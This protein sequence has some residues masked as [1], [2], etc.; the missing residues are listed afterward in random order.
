M[1]KTVLITGSS[2]GIGKA[3]VEYF[4]REGWNVAATMRKP[5][6]TLFSDFENVSVYELDVTKPDTIKK[7]FATATKELGDIDV[8]VNNAGF[9][10]QGVFEAI[11]EQT[12]Q[13]EFD[14]NVFGLMRVSKEAIAHMRG[15]DGGVIVQISSMAG[16]STL[17]LYTMYHASKWAVEGFSE[18]LQHELYQHDI[19]IKI[20]EP[21]VIKT[22]FYEDNEILKPVGDS[23]YDG[24]IAATKRMTDNAV[25]NGAHPAK[26]AATIFKAATD[27][28]SRVRY[29]VAKPAKA[30]IYAHKLAPTK[31][32]MWIVRKAYRL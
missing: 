14:V 16:R 29:A 24:I 8:V 7:T 1:G 21:G 31:L 30:L 11:D 22:E 27:G 13:R 3:T 17:P 32:A 26:V 19:R 12:M 6:K 25:K 23:S 5:R 20:I 10:E 18:A 15:N 9:G 28:N 2:S 4:A